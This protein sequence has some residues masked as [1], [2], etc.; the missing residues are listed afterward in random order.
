MTWKRYVVLL[1]SVTAVWVAALLTVSPF[2]L[3][4]EQLLLAFL[5]STA[6]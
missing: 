4:I 5:A 1:V 3:H 2:A 6:G